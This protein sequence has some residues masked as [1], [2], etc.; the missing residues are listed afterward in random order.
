MSFKVRDTSSQYQS[1]YV[2][3]VP[4]EPVEEK[5]GKKSKKKRKEG[6]KDTVVPFSN[7]ISG[8]FAMKHDQTNQCDYF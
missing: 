2:G 3:T 4:A 1:T 8:G 5:L 6:K 7:P